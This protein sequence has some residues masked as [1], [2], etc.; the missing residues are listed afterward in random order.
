MQAEPRVAPEERAPDPLD[1]RETA[2]VLAG[3]LLR[4]AG[5]DFVTITPET[6][7]RVRARQHT[8]A[9]DLRDVFGWSMPFRLELL[10]PSLARAALDA[11]VLARGEDGLVHSTVRFST[12]GGALYAHSAYPTNSSDAV[13]FG[14]D[15]YR[16]CA[17]LARA[18]PH[19]TRVVDIG[20]G[21]GAGG[22][23]LAARVDQIVL[24]DVN[25][26]ALSFARV[27]AQL[28]GV[29][30]RTSFVQSDVLASVSGAFDLAITNPPYLVDQRKR[31]YRDGGEG[32]GTALAVRIADESIAR[33]SNGGRLL[34]YSGAPVV[35][36]RDLLRSTLEARLAGRL[37]AL[38]YEE[39]DAD[40]FG[41]EL[42]A[43]AY[44]DVERIA[45]VAVDARKP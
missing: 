42:D 28:A 15:T 41:E 33:L 1:R 29:L 36:G 23:S 19:A 17:F 8:A 37:A 13:F 12:L 44:G 38:A 16:Y 9:R 14:P 2:L 24:T 22:L 31:A 6:H 3:E 43:P 25:P 40:V 26:R 5:Y 39:L 11:G 35:D 21:S 4:A 34:L 18:A 30:A 10:H 27:N 45:A 7:R 32:L 20:C